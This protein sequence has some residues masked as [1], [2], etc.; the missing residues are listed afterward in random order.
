[1]GS[2]SWVETPVE[3]GNWMAHTTTVGWYL[4]HLRYSKA[5]PTVAR[6]EGMK[7]RYRPVCLNLFRQRVH[8]WLWLRDIKRQFNNPGAEEYILLFIGTL[9]NHDPLSTAP[10]PLSLSLSITFYYTNIRRFTLPNY[11]NGNM[12]VMDQERPMAVSNIE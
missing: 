9:F 5:I 10:N 6:Y 2:S 4:R 8:T 3:F 11:D 7:H 1:M 12:L